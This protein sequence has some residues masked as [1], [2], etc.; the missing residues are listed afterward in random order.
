[1][2]DVMN[3]AFQG[4]FYPKTATP[5][6]M[7]DILPLLQQF[8]MAQWVNFGFFVAYGYRQPYDFLDKGY[9]AKL[10]N[11]DQVYREYRRQIFN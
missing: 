10:A 2:W 9:I 4:Q 8:S 11:P 6:F 3:D 7:N 1:M 5:S